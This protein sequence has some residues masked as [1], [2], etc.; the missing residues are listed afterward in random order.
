MLAA[1]FGLTGDVE[2]AKVWLAET[3]EL[4]PT[5]TSLARLP[6]EWANWNA[7]PQ[8]V[9]LR[10]TTLDVGLRRTGMPEE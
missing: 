5:W 9:A 8:F 3:L 2:E 10:Q 7:S 1:A 4:R 6:A